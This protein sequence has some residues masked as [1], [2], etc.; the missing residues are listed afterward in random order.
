MDSLQII[1]FEWRHPESPRFQ[2][3]AK[4]SPIANL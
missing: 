1:G 2:Q 3:R 4:G